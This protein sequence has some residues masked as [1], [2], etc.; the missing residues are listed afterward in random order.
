MQGAFD[1]DHVS[2]NFLLERKLPSGETRG[3]VTEDEPIPFIPNAPS[4]NHKNFH[5]ERV[6]KGLFVQVNLLMRTVGIAPRD[7]QRKPP[8]NSNRTLKE[9]MLRSLLNPL[10]A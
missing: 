1:S 8:T 10:M 3:L 7:S 5:E 2:K 4:S 9:Q 6:R